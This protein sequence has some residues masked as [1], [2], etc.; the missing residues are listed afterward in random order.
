M[1]VDAATYR[2]LWRLANGLLKLTDTSAVRD[3]SGLAA[4]HSCVSVAEIV[5]PT[6]FFAGAGTSAGK[7]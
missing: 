6:N 4:D 1:N 5:S 7:T 2:L 3:P